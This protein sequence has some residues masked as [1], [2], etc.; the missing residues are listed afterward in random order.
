MDSRSLALNPRVAP[1]AAAPR[2]F[3]PLAAAALAA[4]LLAGCS[5]TA[6]RPEPAAVATPAAPPPAT[7]SS[8][9]PVAVASVQPTAPSAPPPPVRENRLSPATRSLVAQA[10]ALQGKG[11]LVGAALTLERAIRIE[12][13]NPLL[14]IETGRL[15]LAESD[16]RQAESC[17]RK[18]LA[19]ASGDRAAQG[20]AGRLLA[21]ALRA[22][23]RNVE[24]VDVERQPFMR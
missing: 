4:A 16:A 18:A 23:G 24:A 15:R 14:W 8:T 6:P 3:A 7:V 11:D 21:Q 2:T 12:P 22:Q 10:H 9:A 13:G 1:S 20:Q 17:A 19:L 5:L